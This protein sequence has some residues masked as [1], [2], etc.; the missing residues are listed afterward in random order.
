MVSDILSRAVAAPPGL[1][2]SVLRAT[3]V[4]HL[5]SLHPSPVGDVVV[6]RWDDAVTAVAPE[7]HADAMLAD[8]E[9]RTGIPAYPEDTPPSGWSER[10]DEA[11]ASGMGSRVKVALVGASRFQQDVLNATARIPVGET[12]PYGWVA[13]ESDHPGA[14]RA[15]G[16]AL[17]RNPIP[18]IIPCHR[19]VRSDGSL[20][21]YAFGAPMKA[22]LL[23]AEHA[24]P[25]VD[26]PL[27]GAR[28]GEVVCYPTCRHARR[29]TDPVPF[30]SIRTA[31]RA[32]YR[33][34]RVCRPM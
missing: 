13:R 14:V 30:A 31:E 20:G 23:E 24:D 27:V 6:V 18:L 11:L 4:A 22:A 9:Q 19:V 29:I 15:V 28:R 3:G 21:N 33:P 26:A 32:G 5:A 7:H 2:E 17:G 10:I 16:T 34:C 1:V 12:R 25:R 8:Y